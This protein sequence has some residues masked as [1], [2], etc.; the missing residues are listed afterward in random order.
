MEAIKHL[1]I[2]EMIKITD[3]ISEADA[4]IAWHA[5]LKKNSDIQAVAKS[6]GIPVFVTKVDA[7]FLLIFIAGYASFSWIFLF[8]SRPLWRSSLRLFV[9]L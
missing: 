6:R 8:C 5:K 3:N 2:D 1:G 4:F 9:L 7:I